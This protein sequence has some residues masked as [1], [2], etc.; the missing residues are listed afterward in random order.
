MPTLVGALVPTKVGTYRSGCMVGARR[1]ACM[2]SESGIRPDPHC[3]VCA[4][5]VPFPGYIDYA[6]FCRGG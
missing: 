1:C 4:P 5:G 3:P 6:A 2:V